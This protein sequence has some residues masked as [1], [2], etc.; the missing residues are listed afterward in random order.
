M[1]CPVKGLDL[2]HHA[3]IEMVNPLTGSRLGLLLTDS[4]Q[5]SSDFKPPVHDPTKI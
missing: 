3:V 1:N 4:T 5:V 2:T